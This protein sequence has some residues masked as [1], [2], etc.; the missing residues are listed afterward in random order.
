[1]GAYVKKAITVDKIRDAPKIESGAYITR[2]DHHFTAQGP[3][4]GS[5]LL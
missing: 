1:M 4:G 5:Y 3:E 2:M